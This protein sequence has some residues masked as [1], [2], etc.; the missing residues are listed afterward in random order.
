M[1]ISELKKH[2]APHASTICQELYPD[3]RIESGHFKIGSLDG[4]SGRSLSVILNG[5]KA[6][7]WTDFATTQHGDLLDLIMTAQG[8]SVLEAK[9]WGEKRFGIKTKRVKISPAAKTKYATP[10]P[11]KQVNTELLHSFLEARGFKEVGELV[12]RHKIY[13]T[14]ELFT[15]G[16]DLV[17]QFFDPKGK[18]V[19]L[20]HKAL[21]YDGDPGMCNQ[22]GLKQIFYGWHT[23]KPTDRQVWITEGELDAIAA[24]E[25]GFSALSLPSGANSVNSAKAN[26]YDNLDR[27]D[28][29][30][31]ATDMDT[32]GEE[33]AE[34]LKEG[35]GDR[36]IRIKIPSKDIN[37][38]LKEKG[39]EVARQILDHA[40]DEAK[41]Q[42][43]SELFSALE[44]SEKVDAVFDNEDE[45]VV[46][47]RYGFDKIDRHDVRIRPHELH[48]FTGYNGSGK[49]LFLGQ[50]CLNLMS[51]G[52]KVCIASM[53]ME[54][55]ITLKRMVM[56]ASAKERPDQ[57]YRNRIY[58]WWS[59]KLW[60]FHAG[61]TPSPE[62]LFNTFEYAYRRYG[63]T[64]FVIDSLTNL[65]SQQDYEKQQKVVETC[66]N[67][68]RSFP[69]TV[70][71]VT[72]VKKGEDEYAQ[73]N[74]F[75][76]KG[77]GAITD[78]A[79][80]FVSIWKNKRKSEHLAECEHDQRQPDRDIKDSPDVVFSVLK[81]R[82]GMWEG[83]S[84]FMFDARSCQYL[85]DVHSS[86]KPYVKAP[87]SK[88]HPLL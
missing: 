50:V 84:G 3:G 7:M 78:L 75:D 42:D 19:F 65:S 26:E 22:A 66:V 20:K 61:L 34:S 68:K 40:F 87:P 54:P 63:V 9:A 17:F 45:S 18:L 25:L 4:E 81:N 67:L 12:Y 52:K 33:A 23:V 38:L 44:F 64:I 59:Q 5:E 31:I 58:D 48:G 46:G 74:K 32:A 35:F 8:L 70:F 47:V 16:M 21:D 15:D 37:D 71:L 77:S 36:C 2:L 79:D 41:Y 1:Q 43:P 73:P 49:S 56:Q 60:L 29:I 6:G 39:Y 86:P 57:T 51:Q 30:V 88:D 55:E 11:P 83:K 13:A 80:T 72:H 53:E 82:H 27:F 10:K 85:E 28:E 24:R 62:T 76:V 14:D 69:V